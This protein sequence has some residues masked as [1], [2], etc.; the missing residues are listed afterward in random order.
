[1]LSIKVEK[2]I[3]HENKI[4][5]GLTMRQF[6]SVLIAA[7]LCLV[8]YLTTRLDLNALL[9]AFATIGCIAGVIGWV[10]KDG[11]H[12][13]DYLI[14]YMKHIIY[15]DNKLKY[16]TSNSYVRLFNAST[17]EETAGKSKKMTKTEKTELERAKKE[18]ARKVK[19]YSK[20]KIK[21]YE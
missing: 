12:A 16:R 8:V 18:D 6:L 17:K 11:L 2:E 13:E 21:A 9:P 15:H 7:I 19:E 4:I 5:A 10:K 20:A 14:R 1:M 3:Q